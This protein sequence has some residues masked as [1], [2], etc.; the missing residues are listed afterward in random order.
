MSEPSF[1][2]GNFVRKHPNAMDDIISIRL[3]AQDR[4][5]LNEL[6]VIL[7]IKED[8]KAFK[9]ALRLAKNVIHSTFGAKFMTY[10]CAGKRSRLD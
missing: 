8:G 1:D 4:A 7:N 3:N 10:L 6:R 9:M 2:K 5:D